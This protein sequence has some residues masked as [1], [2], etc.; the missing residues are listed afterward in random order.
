MRLRCKDC[1]RCLEYEW[2]DHE[3]VMLHDAL[4]E[5]IADHD[6]DLLCLLCIEARL[7]RGIRADDLTDAPINDHWLLANL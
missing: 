2:K 3:Y 5:S 4:W 7:G 1:G 6:E